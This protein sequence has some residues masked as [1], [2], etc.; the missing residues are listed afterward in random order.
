MKIQILIIFLLV[1]NVT[2]TIIVSD[3]VT[4]RGNVKFRLI[5]DS[6]S[7]S[8]IVFSKNKDI[9]LQRGWGR[10]GSSKAF[11]C[12]LYT[13]QE[14]A[15][16]LLNTYSCPLWS[17]FATLSRSSNF[18]LMRNNKERQKKKKKTEPTRL[19]FVT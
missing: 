9:D 18:S 15:K 10:G 14:I 1:H 11:P 17:T 5:R 19:I 16:R 3:I 4:I 12:N 2:D 8:P 13:Q 7:I 6:C